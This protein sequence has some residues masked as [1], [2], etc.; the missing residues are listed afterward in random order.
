MIPRISALRPENPPSKVRRVPDSSPHPLAPSGTPR[1]TVVIVNF[2]GWPDVSRLVSSLAEAPEVRSGVCEIIV[3]DNASR[4]P[5]PDF[6]AAAPIGVRLILRPDNGGFAVGVN[7]GWQASRSPWL[8]LLNPD[9]EADPG[10][11]G[12]ILGR[13]AHHEGRADGPPGVVGFALKNPDGSRQPS[14]GVEPG[15]VRSVLGQFIP[16]SR[17]KYQADW[18]VKSGP[19][20]WVT[21]ACLLVDSDVMRQLG[22]MDEEFFLYYEEVALCRSA[23]RLGRRVEF[24]DS[25]SVVHL[26]PL[27]NRP[28]SPKMRVIVRHAK[29]LF[30]RKHLPRW[31]F[32]VLCRV[33]ASEATLQGMIARRRGDAAEMGS[34]RAIGS[35][36]RSLSQGKSIA[37]REVLA[38]AE[39]AI[40]GGTV[41]RPHLARPGV[42]SR[43]S[44]G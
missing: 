22:G 17:R 39:A 15:L 41:P 27:Q 37:G 10:V 19:V 2:E 26:R 4:G 13:I 35:I 36:A 38:L 20:P 24:D 3:V 34:W 6:F 32:R 1:L 33:V 16:R 11:I 14:V 12:A 23:R 5:V 28:I 29:L 44:G 18:R 42:E 7:A 43:R 21:G 25:V 40:S 8:L 9:V 30:F 31:Q